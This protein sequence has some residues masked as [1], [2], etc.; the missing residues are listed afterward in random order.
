VSNVAKRAAADIERHS[1]AAELGESGRLSGR[2]MV[3]TPRRARI[4]I[5]ADGECYLFRHRTSASA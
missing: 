4:T 5:R 3:D 1:E 2:A